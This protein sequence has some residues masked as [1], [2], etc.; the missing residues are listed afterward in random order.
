MSNGHRWSKFWWQDHRNET[1]LRVCSLAA[2]GLWVEM[3]CVAHKADPVGYVTVN[4]LAP[5]VRNLANIVGAQEREVKKL[6]AELEDAGVFSR[7]D[8]GV[9]YSRRMVREASAEAEAGE[10]WRAY[11]KNGG[12]PQII[13]GT[14]DKAERQRPYRRSDSPLKTERIFQRDGGCCHWCQVALVRDNP[15][16]PQYFHVDHIIAV[17]DGGGVEEDNL[18]AACQR[19]NMN[20]AR[21]G[22]TNGGT[23]PTS[24]PNG[25]DTSDSNPAENPTVSLGRFRQQARQQPTLEADTDSEAEAEKKRK[26]ISPLPSNLTVGSR[27][28]EETPPADALRTLLDEA[29]EPP[30]HHMRP[31]KPATDS[32]GSGPVAAQ[33]SRVAKALSVSVPYGVVRSAETQIAQLGQQSEV[34]DTS[35]YRWQPCDPVR[36]VEEQLAILRGVA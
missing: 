16:H 22:A 8:D 5:S 26:K 14:V 11:G 23:D 18:V 21:H 1:A 28:R 4:G 10:A 32:V 7:T 20:R 9:I 24:K 12:N 31:L 6:L 35:G 30:H 13:R 19:C 25:S 27:A 33:V 17:R 2:R 34:V 36:T 15:R 29:G 3:L